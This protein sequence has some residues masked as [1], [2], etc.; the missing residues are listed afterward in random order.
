MYLMSLCYL[1]HPFAAF[2]PRLQSCNRKS[3]WCADS[4]LKYRNYPKGI[5]KC[6]MAVCLAIASFFCS[7]HA[8]NLPYGTMRHLQDSLGAD[9]L[10]EHVMKEAKVTA[11]R[12]LF[13]TKNDTT[14][15]DMDALSLKSS[16]MLRDAFEKLP[17]MSFRN[18]QL[19][20]NG[21]EVKRVLVNG[22]NFSSKNPMMALQALPAYIIKNV[23]VY[24]RKSDFAMRHDVDDG[25]EELVADVSVRRKYMGTW[26]GQLAVG[27]GTDSRFL[28]KAF[29]NTFTDRYR[30]SLFGNANN[31]NEQMW[32][33][34][35]GKERAGARQAGDN[36]FYTPGATFFWKNERDIKEKGYFFLEGGMDYNK[37][38][39]DRENK[40]SS[41]LFL[42]DGSMFSI[43]DTHRENNKDRLAGHLKAD[44][45]I[46]KFLT[47]NYFGSV[48]ANWNKSNSSTLKA[49]WNENPIPNGGN[50]VD[51]LK[52]L[53]TADSDRPNVIDLQQ[54][55]SSFD[56]NGITYDHTLRLSYNIPR[57]R[58][59]LSFAH[60][61]NLD[62]NDNEEY[63]STYYKYF[64]DEAVNSTLINRLLYKNSNNMSQGVM[65]RV[66]KYFDVKGFKRLCLY[67]EYN[68]NRS[69]STNDE[70]GYLLDLS[71]TN[72]QSI[73]DDET[74]RYW[75]SCINH[76]SVRESFSFGKG[77][78]SFQMD[79]TY[80]YRHDE[81]TYTKR[82][83]PVLSP[84]KDYH[85]LSLHT[86]FRMR[87]EKTGTLFTQYDIASDIPD[88]RSFVTYPDK[89]DPQYILLG[90]DKLEM[91]LRHIL[92][93]WYS[94]D[95]TKE[96]ENG[97]I[98]RTLSAHIAYFRRNN[99][100]TD[101]TTYDR[102]TGTITVKPVNV[103]GNW[104]GKA[105]IGFTTPLDVKQRFWIET[106]G[107]AS[108]LRTQTYSGVVTA[109]NT[110]QQFNDNRFHSYTASVKPRMR[111]ASVDLSLA[112]ELTVEAN[113]GTY[114]SV[115]SDARWQHLLTGKLNWQLPFRINLNAT[116]NYHNYAGYVSG[117]RENWVMLDIGIERAFLRKENLFVTLS[118]R[119]MLDQNNGFQRQY[120]ATALTHTYQKTLG[121]YGMLTLK[122]RFSPKKK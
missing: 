72:E 59:Y 53:V 113:H 118:V 105:N 50:I 61:M 43:S 97:K 62:N 93:A 26:T 15:Y 36:S 60:K 6:G 45:N 103:S 104:E 79:A 7:A 32:Y 25:K 11:T 86:A 10:K 1:R 80:N 28:G 34:G 82:N 110:E 48:D 78:Y 5:R 27:G 4:S 83:L 46:S 96:R 89:A 120:S 116:L 109:D 117:K 122:Y 112:Y 67:T 75:K 38:M 111:I 64:N 94:R 20:H 99:V 73:I 70:R 77:I 2:R 12:F 74:T 39:Y 31:I 63:N 23:K 102:N 81:M 21:R 18:G 85:Y 54:K 22:M 47:L 42:S 9:S 58:I 84:Q 49:N 88:I 16:D 76:H 114:A 40:Q 56:G 44:W 17:G 115:N 35:D 33:S 30:V 8:A 101:F 55:E 107:E 91:G 52:Y 14:I 119:D 92:T 95:F 3:Q 68:Y 51:T 29:G 71:E 66:M 37:E 41:E 121:R 90:N 13:V 106:A 100:V 108:V 98:T 69:A 87:S 19:Y 24:E 65:G 57:S